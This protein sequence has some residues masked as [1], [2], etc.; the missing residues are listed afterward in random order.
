MKQENT[1]LKGFAPMPPAPL[2]WK[3]GCEVAKW[4]GVSEYCGCEVA[5]WRCLIVYRRVGHPGGSWRR[6]GGSKITPRRLLGG[7]GSS[8]IAP[9]RLPMPNMAQH[10]GFPWGGL[11]G[12]EIKVGNEALFGPGGRLQRGVLS[13]RIS[14]FWRPVLGDLEAKDPGHQY[15]SD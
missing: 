3:C 7:F 2:V 8:K 15:L 5:K 9:W 12:P 11:G 4:R 10:R 6:P 13:L 14:E 1:Y